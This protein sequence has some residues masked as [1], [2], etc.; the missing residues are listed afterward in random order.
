MI[1]WGMVTPGRRPVLSSCYLCI[2]MAVWRKRRGRSR[3]GLTHR[4]EHSYRH[5]AHTHTHKIA[6]R[7]SGQVCDACLRCR[8]S[9]PCR[10]TRQSLATWTTRWTPCACGPHALPTTSISETVS[11]S[12][13]GLLTQLILHLFVIPYQTNTW[14]SFI[15][16]INM[17]SYFLVVLWTIH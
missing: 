8:W 3:N 10:T 14:K 13:S 4:Y 7:Y 1:G 16:K 17:K 11:H 5:T 15:T 2:S 6:L 9:W 12:H